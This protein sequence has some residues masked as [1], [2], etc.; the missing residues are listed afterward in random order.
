MAKIEATPVPGGLSQCAHS[1]G[2]LYGELEWEEL[3][4][5]GKGFMLQGS[6]WDRMGGLTCFPL[7]PGEYAAGKAWGHREELAVVE[8][9]SPG[10]RKKLDGSQKGR[11]DDQT[12]G[13]PGR[14]LGLGGPLGPSSRAFQFLIG[15]RGAGAAGE[16]GTELGLAPINPVES[17]IVPSLPVLSGL[18]LSK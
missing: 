18:Q 7:G 11:E 8:N 16:V 14:Q 10:R 9:L 6:G 3:G 12:L 5:L 1:P 13:L 15:H 2:K 4:A 17:L